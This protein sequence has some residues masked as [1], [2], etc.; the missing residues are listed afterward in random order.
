[1]VERTNK[2]RHEE[3]DGQCHRGEK[4]RRVR[5]TGGW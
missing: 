4:V 2:E 1:M 3:S 5:G